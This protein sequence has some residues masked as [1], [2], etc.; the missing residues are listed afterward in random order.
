MAEKQTGS[1]DIELSKAIKIDGA[2]IKALRMREPT[3]ADQL[4]VS[5]ITDQVEAEL[6]MLANLCQVAPR[7]LHQ[8]TMRDYKKVQAAYVGFTD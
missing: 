1:V 6:H 2:N 4:A 3:V 8:L 7:D 5:K